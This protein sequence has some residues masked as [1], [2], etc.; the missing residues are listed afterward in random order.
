MHL[1]AAVRAPVVAVFG[2]RCR[3][4]TRRATPR[5]RVVRVDLWCAPCNQIRK[6]PARCQGHT[7]DCLA[8]VTV[9]A[10]I[11]AALSLAAETERGP[12][13]TRSARA[14]RDRPPRHRARRPLETIDL[15]D[16]GAGAIADEAAG[17]ANAW[18]KSLRPR[19]R[20]R[21]AAARSLPL[22]RRLAVVVRRSCSCTRKA[23][24]TRCGGPR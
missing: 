11:A 5:H 24:S 18:I 9:D 17:R 22:P 12:R 2:R 8:G 6:P 19:R 21:P 13:R 7:P 1:A 3:C 4:A 16:Y 20:R 23:S 14:A 10:V 15:D